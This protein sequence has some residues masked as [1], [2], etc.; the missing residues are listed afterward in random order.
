MD[1]CSKFKCSVTL[2]LD[3][4]KVTSTYSTYRTTSTPNHVTVA[5]CNTEIRAFEFHEI[6]T[7]GEVWTLVIAFQ[8]GNSKIGLRQAV[9]LVH[10]P[11]YHHQSSVL[12]SM[13]NG[14]G[15]RP[16]KVQFSQILKLRD[17]LKSGRGHTGAHMWSRSTYRPNYRSKSEKLCGRTDGLHFELLRLHFESVNI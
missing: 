12:S 7:F 10:V 15:D 16:R 11:Y 1:N 9:G 2:T 13:Q 14:G 8:E 17:D 4:V 3:R 6:W 5:S